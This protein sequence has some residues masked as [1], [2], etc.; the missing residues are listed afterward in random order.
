MNVV[1]GTGAILALPFQTGIGVA[2]ATASVFYVEIAHLFSHCFFL[3]PP[4]ISSLLLLMLLL[5]LFNGAI[6][7]DKILIE[8]VQNVHHLNC[9]S[10]FS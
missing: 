3:S 5:L 8:K 4:P 10:H 7:L 6:N 9:T 1:Q 2:V